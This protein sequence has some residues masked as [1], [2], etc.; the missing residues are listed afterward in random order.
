MNDIE[1]LKKAIQDLHGCDSKHMQAVHVHETFQGNVVWDGDVE[2]FLLENHP[3]AG[4]A[5]AWSYETDSGETRYVAILGLP[6]VDT[7]INAVRAY[8]VAQTQKEK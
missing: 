8:I 6:P 7:A 2:V 5:Y 1:R 4:T 3:E